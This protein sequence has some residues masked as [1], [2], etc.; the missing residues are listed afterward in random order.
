MAGA[1][2]YLHKAGFV[3]QDIKPW[4]IIINDIGRAMLADFGIGHSFQSAGMVV[5]SPAFQAPEALD[6]DVD[7]D[8][9]GDDHLIAPQKEDVWA[10]G[11]TLYQLLFMRL[12]FPG[13]NLYEIVNYI[14]EHELQV[15]PCDPEIEALIRGMLTVDPATRFGIDDVVNHPLIQGAADLA[16][17]LPPVPP[18]EMIVGDIVQIDAVVCCPGTSFARL[19]ARKSDRFKVKPPPFAR[20][21]QFGPRQFPPVRK[22]ASDTDSADDEPLVM[23]SPVAKL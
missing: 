16:T 23:S 9:C 7:E 19:A 21:S 20:G 14:R 13:D 10:L 15:G 22:K 11:V 2:K 12:P 5:G 8:L 17:D 4:N 3:H 1:I 6:D 18:P